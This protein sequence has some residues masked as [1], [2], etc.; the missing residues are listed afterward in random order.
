LNASAPPFAAT[1]CEVFVSVH[2]LAKNINI[3]SRG[4][5]QVVDEYILDIV[6]HSHDSGKHA[7]SDVLGLQSTQLV[8]VFV[9]GMPIPKANGK[10]GDRQ[11]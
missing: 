1:C 5:H 3:S 8:E 4:V 10:D 7:S 9:F 2:Y 11:I 6:E